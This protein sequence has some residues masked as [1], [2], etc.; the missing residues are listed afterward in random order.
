MKNLIILIIFK[1]LSFNILATET[2]SILAIVNDDLIMTNSISKDLTKEE[3]F[4]VLN[5]KIESI[6][7]MQKIKELKIKPN[8][9]LVQEVLLDVALQNNL[10][11]PQ[12]QNLPQYKQIFDNIMD[13]L[14]KQT[15]RQYIL[16][17]A[18]IVV[19]ED[20]INQELLTNPTDKKD[21]ISQIKIAQI[22]IN[23]I[24]ITKTNQDKSKDELIKNLLIDLSNR[25]KNG[26]SFSKLAKT[27]SQDPSYKNGGESEW[28]DENNQSKNFK[29]QLST[30]KL[31]QLSKPFKT[32]QG[33]RIMKIT[34]KRNYNTHIDDIKVKLTRLKQDSYFEN[35]L[36]SIKEK[37]YINIFE[38]KL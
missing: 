34:N 5:N 26:A 24:D 16:R 35:W 11:L 13:Y 7:Q 2:N 29:K 4:A 10:N 17:N 1:I 21:L 37:S 8:E 32:E 36:K 25:I 20:E 23:S 31:N 22:L 9:N 33:W 14:L 15:L 18:N 38:H 28:L 19:T 12:L 3:R 6:L 27:Y 30:L